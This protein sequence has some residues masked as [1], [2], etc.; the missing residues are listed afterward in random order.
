MWLTINRI[1]F[2]FGLHPFRLHC[3]TYSLF[4]KGRFASGN[5]EWRGGTGVKVIS[6]LTVKKKV[7]N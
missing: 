3:T 2:G 6:P 4:L 5:G 1:D 7:S